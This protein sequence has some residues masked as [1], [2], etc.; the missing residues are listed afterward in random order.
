LDCEPEKITCFSGSVLK[1][2]F[3]GIALGKYE[4]QALKVG[5]SAYG[6]LCPLCA[7]CDI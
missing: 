7:D 1:V 3:E 4:G 6:L 2:A 5:S